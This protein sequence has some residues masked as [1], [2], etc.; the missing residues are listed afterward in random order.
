MFTLE[1][2]PALEDDR[3]VSSKLAGMQA[4]LQHSYRT[5]C[6]LSQSLRDRRFSTKRVE[7]GA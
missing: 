6:R 7:L 5:C 2:L 3:L 1:R 4:I